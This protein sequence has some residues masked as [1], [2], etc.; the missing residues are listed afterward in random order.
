M[1]S[2]PGLRGLVAP[3]YAGWDLDITD[4]RRV[5]NWLAEFRQ[6]EANGNLPQLS[7]IRLPNDHTAGTRAGSPTPRA[8]VAEND[9]ALGRLVEAISSSVYWRGP[10]DFCPP[11]RRARGPGTA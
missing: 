9:L 10:G 1:E 4:G 3:F 2:V 7:I 6:F 5:D 11:G 8:M